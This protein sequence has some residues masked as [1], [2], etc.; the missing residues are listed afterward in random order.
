MN[1]MEINSEHFNS[2]IAVIVFKEEIRVDS[3]VAIESIFNKRN[4]ILIKLEV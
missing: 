1:F 4:I 3:E 2:L